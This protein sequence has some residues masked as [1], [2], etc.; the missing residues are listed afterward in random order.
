MNGPDVVAYYK[1]KRAALEQ[2]LVDASFAAFVKE[3]TEKIL[4]VIP[5]RS[6]WEYV[7]P[8]TVQM[9]L[10]KEKVDTFMKEHIWDQDQYEFGWRLLTIRVDGTRY[11]RNWPKPN[12]VM[13]RIR[14]ESDSESESESESDCCFSQHKL[15]NGHP[16]QRSRPLQRR[17][18]HGQLQGQ[19]GRGGHAV[20][21][22][23]RYGVQED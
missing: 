23:V 7:F 4:T 13:K 21:R 3:Y 6:T 17:Q 20:L 1:D 2:A 18:D 22:R 8:D 9:P 5:E 11:Q 16:L 15:K 19:A 14:V 12:L 10:I